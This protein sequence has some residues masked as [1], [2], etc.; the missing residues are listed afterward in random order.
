MVIITFC[1]NTPI[2]AA[3]VL[4]KPILNFI[5]FVFF[6]AV[7]VIVTYSLNSYKLVQHMRS[8]QQEIS[9]FCTSRCFCGTKA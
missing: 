4:W 8:S 9:T 2:F 1:N 6:R 5:C 7:F 3:G